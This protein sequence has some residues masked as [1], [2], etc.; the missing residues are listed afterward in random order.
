MN[1]NR[2][3]NEHSKLVNGWISHAEHGVRSGGQVNDETFWAYELMSKMCRIDPDAA[4]DVIQQIVEQVDDEAILAFLGSG[5]LEDLLAR[6]GG[7]VIDRVVDKLAS[8]R[9]FAEVARVVWQNVIAPDV[10]MR[11]QT[12]LG[13]APPALG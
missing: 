8:N 7:E 2:S 5:P 6:H 10:W 4:W 9:K 3:A 13:H 12:A 1:S 11:L